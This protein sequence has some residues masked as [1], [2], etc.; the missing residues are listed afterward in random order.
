MYT[1]RP[2][3]F[4]LPLILMRIFILRSRD[5]DHCSMKIDENHRNR[6]F[7]IIFNVLALYLKF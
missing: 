6:K 5:T 2:T 3:F 7:N 4:I 1:E